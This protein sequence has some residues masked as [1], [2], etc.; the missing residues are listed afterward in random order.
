ML[1]IYSQSRFP[2]AFRVLTIAAYVPYHFWHEADPAVTRLLQV[3]LSDY[4]HELLL[5]NVCGTPLHQQHGSLDDNVPPSHS[6]RL[7]LLLSQIDCPSEYVELPGKGHW[8][9]GVMTTQNLLDFYDKV[10]EFR[11]AE[12]PTFSSFTFVVS[13]PGTMG[14]KG[15]IVVDQLT[16]PDFPG[17]ITA[18]YDPDANFW[19]LRTS[20]VHRLHFLPSAA[21]NWMRSRI[22]VDGSTLKLSEEVPISSQWLVR[23][24]NGFWEVRRSSSLKRPAAE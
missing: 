23:L 9:D 18:A 4:R 20:N 5:E 22:A 7:S 8:F 11:L 17:R 13:S 14:S 16:S 24:L 2:A 1:Y 10:L 6:R 21:Q 3:A 12:R 19:H 15:G